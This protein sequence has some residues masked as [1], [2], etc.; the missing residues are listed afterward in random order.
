MYLNK[1]KENPQEEKKRSQNLNHRN[2]NLHE[3]ELRV[4]PHHLQGVIDP[5]KVRHKVMNINHYNKRQAYE[6]KNKTGLGLLW[7]LSRKPTEKHNGGE[8]V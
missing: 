5:G 7:E 8:H 6:Q 4:E 2:S 3:R 1:K